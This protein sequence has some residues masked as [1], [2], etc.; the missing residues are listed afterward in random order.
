MALDTVEGLFERMA[1][2]GQGAYGLS[3]VT[4]LEHG[5]QS[6]ALAQ[7]RQ[8]GEAATIGALFHDIGHLRTAADESLAE[9]GIDDRHEH[10]SAA[11]LARLFGQAVSE[12]VRLHVAAKRYLCTVE[13]DYFDRLS[14]DSVRSLELQGGRMSPK[15][16]TAFEGEPYQKEALALRRIDE[17]AKVAGLQVPGLDHYRS[18]AEELARKQAC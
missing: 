9:R 15:E 3:A 17:D 5:L 4:Q 7:K 2:L 13:S 14:P 6:A 18:M 1:R 16:V 8:L 10:A 12:P 11:I